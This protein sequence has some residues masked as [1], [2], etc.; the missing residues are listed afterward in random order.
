MRPKLVV[1]QPMDEEG[2]P[3]GALGEIGEATFGSGVQGGSAYPLE[4]F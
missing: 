3:A 4:C 1:P 2:Q